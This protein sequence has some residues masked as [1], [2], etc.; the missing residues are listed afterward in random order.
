M[1]EVSNNKRKCLDKLQ[2]LSNF[3]NSSSSVG[4]LE[5]W[6]FVIFLGL[7]PVL[8]FWLL[9]SYS[10]KRIPIL[11]IIWFIFLA[12]VAILKKKKDFYKSKLR[13]SKIDKITSLIKDDKVDKI[14]R[15]ILNYKFRKE[16]SEIYK[17][18]DE[19]IS[20]Q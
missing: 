14:K 12:Y 17:V 6:L 4:K 20:N 10:Q 2:K 8:L 19:Y 16:F 18:I 15:E 1:D 3:T 11:L 5:Y 13:Q 7:P 9:E